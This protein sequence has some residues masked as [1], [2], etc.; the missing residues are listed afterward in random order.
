MSE[1]TYGWTVEMQV[2]AINM[3]MRCCEVPVH[4]RRRIGFS[5][6]SGTVKGTLGAGFKIIKTILKYKRE[7]SWRS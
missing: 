4:Y 6:V 3:K 2:K 1:M 7:H 5:K